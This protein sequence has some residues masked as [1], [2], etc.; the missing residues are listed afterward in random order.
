MRRPSEGRTLD[1]A[2]A[3]HG[4]LSGEGVDVHLVRVRVGVKA[5]VGV[6][7]GVRARAWVGV[8]V[9]VGVGVRVG[10]R[11]AGC[12]RRSRAR[13]DYQRGTQRRCLAGWRR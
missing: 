7:V 13:G 12:P 10:V 8:G 3:V 11:G 1:A 9:G 4:G 5:W 2:D 6:K